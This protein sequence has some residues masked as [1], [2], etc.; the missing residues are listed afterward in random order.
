MLK[1]IFDI[2]SKEEIEANI[3]EIKEL[4]NDKYSDKDILDELNYDMKEEFLST[5]KAR[6]R[7]EK[8]LY[9][10]IGKDVLYFNEEDLRFSTPKIIA[11]YRAKKLKCN[12]IV[13]LC[14]GIGVQSNAFSD[15]CKE[16]LA[17]EI[18]PRKVKYA[19]E[20]FKKKNLKFI[21]GDVLSEE[22]ITKVKE[23]SPDTIFVDPERLAGEEERNLESIKPNLK[24]LIK[25]YSK[26]TSNICIEIPPRIENN[27]LKEFECE[28][29]YLTLK[30]KLNRLNLYFGKLKEFDIRVSDA[31]SGVYIYNNDSAKKIKSNHKMGWYIYEISDAVIKAGLLNELGK[32]TEADLLL[33]TDKNKVILT[34]NKPVIKFSCFAECYKVIDKTKN[35]NEVN[36]ILKNNKF[37]KAVIK[38]SIEP[39][40]YWKERNMFEKGLSGNKEAVIF[41]INKEYVIGE[42]V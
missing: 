10:D 18:D 2:Y 17:I 14:S 11:D 29:E 15:S 20:N 25:I 9:K 21:I 42:E 27:K 32:W 5:A 35:I 34:N 33:G 16:V 41:K 22:I 7:N 4:L 39:K 38:Y 24:K 12:K 1:T 23:F 19:E 36:N 31:F 8:D 13:D 37:G 40:D 26:I 30:N 6:L 3:A 28:K